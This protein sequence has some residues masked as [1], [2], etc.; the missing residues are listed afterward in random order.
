MDTKEKENARLREY[1]KRTNNLA[2]K[3]YEKTKKG[4]LVR[5]YRNM[6]SRTNGV[7]KLKSHLYQN[8]EL[9]SRE[10]FYSWS[11][12]DENFNSLFKTW[13]TEHYN[14]KLTPSI[15]RVDSKE[16]Y[17][18]DNMEWITHSENSRRTTRWGY[19]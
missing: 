6:Q 14:Q 11:L 1:R 10:D 17:I 5:C 18:L 15:N 19:A 2:T 8:K 3:K 9:L 12:Q 16:G 7:Q 4:F 13:E